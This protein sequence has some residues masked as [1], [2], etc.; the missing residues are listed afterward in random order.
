[1]NRFSFVPLESIDTD[2]SEDESFLGLSSKKLRKQKK[3]VK[4]VPDVQQP[5]KLITPIIT[6]QF[7][8]FTNFFIII[9]KANN[10]DHCQNQSITARIRIHPSIQIL[11]SEPAWCFGKDANFVRCGFSIDFSRIPS[12]S[13]TSF[14]P[15]VELYRRQSDK[16]I[17]LSF[18]ILPLKVKEVVETCGKTLT[19]LYR[20]SPVP[21]KDMQTG[22]QMGSIIV[23]VALGFPEHEKYLDPSIDSV[24]T[25]SIWSTPQQVQN[26]VPQVN[27]QQLVAPPKTTNA[28]KTKKST[29]GRRSKR[30][31]YS[32]DE[33]SPPRRHR[34]QHDA[35]CSWVEEAMKLGWKPP[36]TVDK[37]WKVKAR[38]KGWIPPN[39]QI[40]SSIGIICDP[41][42]RGLRAMTDVQTDPVKIVDPHEEEEEE[43]EQN[44]SHNDTSDDII[45]LLN[46]KKKLHNDPSISSSTS[47]L[48]YSP[49]CV[50][51]IQK[52]KRVL[53]LVP[54]LSLFEVEPIKID[55]SS[56]SDSENLFKSIYNISVENPMKKTLKLLPLSDSSSSS[57]EDSDDLVEESCEEEKSSIIPIDD[58]ESLSESVIESSDSDEKDDSDE[59]ISDEESSDSSYMDIISK[60]TDSSYREKLN[61]LNDK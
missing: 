51:D 56:D 9:T 28:K 38:Q 27:V 17:L 35:P 58:H 29:K 61:I 46:P 52:P 32:D 55:T 34:K 23:T 4:Q 49:V 14:T 44:F 60:I 26:H 8:P 53:D 11:E 16:D 10:L 31:D 59:E 25:P 22:N 18:A 39:E 36:G 47:S 43:K 57:E 37:D 33:N 1:M 21:L 45:R 30:H 6:E 50:V 12:F 48:E 5:R 19:F 24:K 15:S 40:M 42:E 54:C 20:N 7:E 2:S 41:N 3:N 13:L